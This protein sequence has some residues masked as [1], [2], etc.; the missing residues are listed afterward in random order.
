MDQKTYLSQLK[1]YLKSLPKEEQKGVIEDYEGHFEYARSNGKSD[2]EIIKGLGNSEKVAKE[3]IVQYEITKADRDPSIN[4][5][6]KAVFA[7]LGL[8]IFNLFFVLVPFLSLLFVLI[9][10]FAFSLFLLL[11]PFILLIQEGF[12]ITLLK[13]AFLIMG[14]MGLGIL[15][16][17]INV[18]ASKIIYRGFLK[19]LLFNL[20]KVRVGKL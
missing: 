13:E 5:L 17:L 10:F 8:G 20:E 11:S 14:Y 19:Y 3:A 7:A 16:F 4:N 9:I 6:R 1:E 15:L 12:T 2:Y 18:K